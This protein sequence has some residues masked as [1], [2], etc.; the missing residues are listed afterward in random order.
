MQFPANYTGPPIDDLSTFNTLPEVLQNILENRNGFILYN[1]GLHIRGACTAPIWHSLHE[2]WHGSLALWKLFPEIKEND[3]PFAQDMLG[4]Q[5]ILRNDCVYRLWSETGELET[6][7]C[8]L[9]TFLQQAQANP[10]EV[11][12]L[13]PLTQF[14]SAGKQLQPG[15]LLSAY[16]PFCTQESAQGVS[17]NAVSMHE[18]I[19]FLADF[20][21]QISARQFDVES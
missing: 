21:A 2:V 8:D 9:N 10:D 13:A 19:L 15:Q 14:E 4:D 5:F 1:G 7:D 18:R 6:L 17:L 12:S 16:P 20:A 3:I 11:L